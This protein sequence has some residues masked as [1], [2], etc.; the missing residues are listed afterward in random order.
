MAIGELLNRQKST[1]KFVRLSK[2]SPLAKREAMTGLA[3]IAPWIVGFLVF[4]LIPMVASLVFSFTNL[5]LVMNEPVQWNNFANYMTML[6]IPRWG[7]LAG[8]AQVWFD[9]P[10]RGHSHPAA[11]GAADEQPPP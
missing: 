10:P 8:G 5:Q 6:K 9:L 4:T 7:I 11:A 2:L 1:E 3:F